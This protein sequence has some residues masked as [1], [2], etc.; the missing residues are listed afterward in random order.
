MKA[1]IKQVQNIAK[2]LKEDFKK[3]EEKGSFSERLERIVL[4]F[5]N[6]FRTGNGEVAIEVRGGNYKYLFTDIKV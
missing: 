3:G 5:E 4:G 2:N 1:T 6:A